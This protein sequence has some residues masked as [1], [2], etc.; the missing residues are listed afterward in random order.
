MLDDNGDKVNI[1][2]TNAIH[3]P[4]MDVHS[5]P[6]QQ[7]SQQSDDK[8]AGGDV[9]AEVYYFRWNVLLRTV[10]YQTG[11]NLPILYKLPGRKIAQA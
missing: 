6:L 8:S 3:A 10:P 7:I 4:T 2:I 11:S 9:R 5:I 1:L